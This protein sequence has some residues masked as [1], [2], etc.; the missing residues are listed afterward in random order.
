MKEQ[1]RNRVKRM[2]IFIDELG[3]FQCTNK[4]SAP[5]CVGAVTIPGRHLQEVEDGFRTL[6]ANWLSDE[7]EIK[8]KLLRESDFEQLCEFLEPHAVLFECSVIDMGCAT[9]ADVSRHR[10][11]QAEGMTRALTQSTTRTS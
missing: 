4:P 5:S 6:T 9:E 8:G 11:G 3:G 2:H 7:G 1:K 10:R